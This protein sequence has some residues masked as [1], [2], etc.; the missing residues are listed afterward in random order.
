MTFSVEG[1]IYRRSTDPPEVREEGVGKYQCI[2]R[3]IDTGETV[4]CKLTLDEIAKYRLF[5][6]RF[7]LP[8][9]GEATRLVGDELEEAGVVSIRPKPVKRGSPWGTPLVSKALA[10]HPLQVREF[11]E[12][13]VMHGTGAYYRENGDCELS[14]RGVRKREMERRCI[15]D[16]DAGYGDAQPQHATGSEGE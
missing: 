7:D 14:T 5:G 4:C 10:V 2:F 12:Q 15:F 9:L 8:G 11:N 6:T 16:R 1:P 3:V 13:A